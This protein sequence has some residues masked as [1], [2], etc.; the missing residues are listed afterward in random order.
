MKI[1]IARK[2]I[3]NDVLLQ[4]WYNHINEWYDLHAGYSCGEDYNSFKISDYFY[5]YSMK[6]FAKIAYNKYKIN[7][8]TLKNSLIWRGFYRIKNYNYA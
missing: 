6:Q 3:K 8:K 2:K 5:Q 1:R 4:L 7:R